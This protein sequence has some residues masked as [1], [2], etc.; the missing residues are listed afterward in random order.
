MSILNRLGRFPLQ[1]QRIVHKSIHTSTILKMSTKSEPSSVINKN[2][3][4]GR[5]RS[6]KLKR[7]KTIATL[8]GMKFYYFAYSNY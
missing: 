7:N 1:H 3:T 2:T 6:S 4:V 5:H 8:P